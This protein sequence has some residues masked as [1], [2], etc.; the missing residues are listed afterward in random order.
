M[1]PAMKKKVFTVDLHGVKSYAALHEALVSAL[2]FPDGYGRNLDALHDV[3]TEYG[4]NWKITFLHT[5]STFKT[6][7]LVC[8]DAIEETPGLEIEF[9]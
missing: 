5:A 4:A 7:R 8:Q 1:S 2:P 3:L 9:Q 6:F